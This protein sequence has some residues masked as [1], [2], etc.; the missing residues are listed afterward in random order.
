MD[1]HGFCLLSILRTMMVVKS[2]RIN[3]KALA[4]EAR[5]ILTNFYIIVYIRKARF[6]DIRL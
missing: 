3:A 6:A 2:H 4:R 5:K 1:K